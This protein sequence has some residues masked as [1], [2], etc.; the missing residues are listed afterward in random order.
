MSSANDGATAGSRF[1]DGGELL[2][3]LGFV[4]LG[5]LYHVVPFIV[6]VHRYSDLL[7]Y[8]PVP[9]IDDLYSDRLALGDFLA[10]LAGGAL[11][12][13][14]DV[15][16]NDGASALGGALVLVG[17]VL[18]AWNLLQVVRAHSPHSIPAV[19]GWRRTDGG[20]T[21]PEHGAGGS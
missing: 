4:V 10:F 3:V 2:R 12:L 19:L 1:P 5:T 9:L 16:G 13:L 15:L 20:Q 14:G 7:G 8:E 18:F 17:T 21:D 6:W 11:L